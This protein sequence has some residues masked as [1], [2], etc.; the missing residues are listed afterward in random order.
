MS[1]MTM[2]STTKL[3]VIMKVKRQEIIE[4]LLDKFEYIVNNHVIQIQ[5]F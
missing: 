5:N 3:K 4:R 1:F 2:Y